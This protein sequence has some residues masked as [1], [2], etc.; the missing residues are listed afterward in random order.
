MINNDIVCTDRNVAQWIREAIMS[1]NISM[2][3]EKSKDEFIAILC[4]RGSDF[5]R[6][7]SIIND[8]RNVSTG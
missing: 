6:F 2:M 4:S 8:F 3:D 5:K 7:K 1:M